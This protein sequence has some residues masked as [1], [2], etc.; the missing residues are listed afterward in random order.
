MIALLHNRRK[1]TAGQE[2]P[3]GEG[4]WLNFDLSKLGNPEHSVQLYDAYAGTSAS[5][6]LRCYNLQRLASGYLLLHAQLH[7]HAYL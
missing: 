1:Y 3:T 5:S 2:V 4:E 7:G 6:P